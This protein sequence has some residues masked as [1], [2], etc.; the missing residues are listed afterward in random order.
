MPQPKLY[1]SHAHRQAAYR[2]RCDQARQRQLEEKGLLPLPKPSNMPGTLRWDQML[3]N[4]VTQLCMME[5]EMEQYYDERSETW[6]EGEKG[7]TFQERQDAIS[8][9]RE[10]IEQIERGL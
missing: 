7:Q 8:E 1:P 3:A 6:Q 9:A 5:Q 10:A 2:R 4:I